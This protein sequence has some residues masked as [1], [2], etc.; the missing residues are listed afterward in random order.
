MEI[1][2]TLKTFDRVKC[3]KFAIWCAEKVLSDWEIMWPENK[4]PHLAIE[5]TKNWLANPTEENSKL[6][7]EAGSKVL[8]PYS[9]AYVSYAVRSATY[10]T[11]NYQDYV[12]WSG[13]AA[14]W[15]VM[16]MGQFGPN[17][18]DLLREY[19]N[20]LELNTISLVDLNRGL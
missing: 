6:S 14:S 8:A 11:C 18:A 15:A 7:R 16:A 9:H 20:T 2:N 17:E 12:F 4:G 1:E 3:V 5:V 10:A 13:V 19:V